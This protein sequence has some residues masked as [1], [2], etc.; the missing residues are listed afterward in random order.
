MRQLPAR[1]GPR[2][3]ARE[4]RPGMTYTDEQLKQLW[5]DFRIDYRQWDAEALKLRRGKVIEGKAV[6]GSYARR[7]KSQ[8]DEVVRLDAELMVLDTAIADRETAA[9]S[10]HAAQRAEKIA[11]ISR[12]AM[13]PAN[14]EGPDSGSRP[15]GASGPALVKDARRDRLESPDEV[16]QRMGSNPW[17][18][19]DGP[20]GRAETMS[21][22]VS[23]AHSA[24]EGMEER[25]SRSGAQKLA[26]LLSERPSPFGPYEVRTAEDIRRS[27]ELI[28][29][30][31]SPYYE[32]GFRQILR[33]PEAFRSGTGILMWS[34]EE[35]LAY[36]DVM[37]C[38][39]ALVE[40]TGTGGQYLLPLV[41][42]D[43]IVLTNASSANPWRRV[44]RNVTTTS[45]TWNGVTS[46]GATAVWTAEGATATDGTPTLGALVLTPLKEA[47][48]LMA[49]VE[50]YAD[51]HI[52]QNVP[53]LLADGFARLESAGFATGGGT[54]VPNGA[55]FRATVDANTSL[56]NTANATQVFPLLTALPPRFRIGDQAKPY[57]ACNI[58]ILN[59]PS[60]VND[61]TS[62][63]IPEIFGYD[64][65]ESSDMDS[66]NT[67]GG[68]KNLLF[69]DANSFLIC[70]RLGTTVVWEPLVA[71]S[72][73]ILPSGVVGWFAYRRVTSDC[74]TATALRIHNNA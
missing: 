55:V 69:F 50:E 16:I 59:A 23:R 30:L 1:D 4:R 29:A 39:S 2:E 9:R 48:W 6:L 28:T 71:S 44:C 63:G 46:A 74:T 18:H 22:L 45:K 49:S 20:V 32:S 60:I 67:T 65:L 27:A 40:D 19:E 7:S 72:G 53:A 13:D 10:Q 51:T 73:G 34:D 37:A 33:F 41:L 61:Q 38:R 3:L 26:E 36:H 21:G 54:T 58:A 52:A 35:R 5:D 57:W 17:R 24:I 47:T 14:L 12:A 11:E 64:V 15:Y 43:T 25:L 8:E 42:D 68:H 70:E 66:A 62:D 56:V 31:S